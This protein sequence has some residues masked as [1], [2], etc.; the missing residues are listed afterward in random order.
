MKR[1][2][3]SAALTAVIGWVA[4]VLA[5]GWPTAPKSGLKA[6]SGSPAESLPTAW[7]TIVADVP[8]SL[9]KRSLPTP[10]GGSLSDTPSLGNAP[11]PGFKL[12][13]AEAGVSPSRGENYHINAWDAA[14][15]QGDKDVLVIRLNFI[16]DLAEPPSA[17]LLERTMKEVNDFFV[18]SSYGTLSLT[19]TITPTLT[20]PRSK[21]WYEQKGQSLIMDSA[22]ELAVVSGYDTTLYDFVMIAIGDLPGAQY[23]GWVVSGFAG[24]MFVKGYYVE[25]ICNMM[26]ATFLGSTSRRITGIRLR[27]AKLNRIPCPRTLR[28]PTPWQICLAGTV[29]MARKR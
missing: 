15:S 2:V 5:D 24:G 29:Y 23:E 9:A 18:E 17:D 12:L 3:L 11:R 28:F 10:A 7:R 27:P 21:L 16:D 26:A 1:I 14:I 8:I 25:A 4:L 19:T 22:F 13:G 20:L 6:K